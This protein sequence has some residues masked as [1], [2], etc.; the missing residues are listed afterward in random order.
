M[1]NSVGAPNNGREIERIYV[2]LDGEM[3]INAARKDVWRHVV[4]YPTWQNYSTVQHLAGNPGEE[5]ELVLLK[6]TEA[7][8]ELGPYYARTIKIEPE[9]RFTWKTFTDREELNGFGIVEFRLDDMKGAT[10]FYYNTY[11]EIHVDRQSESKLAELRKQY[12]KDFEAVLLSIF[13]KLKK[14][15]EK[16]NSL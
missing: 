12:Y 9:R 1:S 11:Y 8:I 13:A 5:G 4:N 16:E 10:R 3:T 2:F 15:A 7:G 6:K 14:L